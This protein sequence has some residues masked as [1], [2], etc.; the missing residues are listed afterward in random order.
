[1]RRV[2]VGVVMGLAALFF[3]C[4]T[5]HGAAGEMPKEGAKPASAAAAKVP[6]K[7]Y[8]YGEGVVYRREVY[9][10]SFVQEGSQDGP[11]LEIEGNFASARLPN[12]DCYL[13]H[14]SERTIRK[15]DAA[16]NRVYTIAWGGPY[17]RRGGLPE[18]ARFSGGAYHGIMGLSADNQGR[19]LIND[20]Y[21]RLRW[22][23]NPET[24]SIEVAPGGDLNA[25]VSGRAPDG[26]LYYAMGDGKL[27]KLLP[28]G[29]TVQ[30]LGVTLEPPL[31]ITSYFGGLAVSEPTG[32]LYAGSRD[33]YSPW[34]VFWYWDMKTGKALGLAGPKIVDGKRVAQDGGEVDK[35]FHCASGPADKVGFW[36]T[37][38]PSLGPDLGE[39]YLYI[40]GGD[41]STPSRLDLKKRYV[42][43]L[44]RAEPKGD[45]SLWTFGEGRQ[46]R[47]YRFGDP[48]TWPGAPQ[49]GDDGEF[50][51]GA[52]GRLEVFRPVPDKTAKEAEP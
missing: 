12:G 50:Y 43:K 35:N 39:R 37:G 22:V 13:L 18:C 44:V 25:A 24:D 42:T 11:P 27:K 2:A 19:L 51:M 26:S 10:G 47:D 28:D 17:G 33:P 21:N 29:K 6:G 45:R 52:S 8:P 31:V 20:N 9:L 49:W 36:C 16:R 34:G 40:P 14:P 7:D 23:L 4:G 1:M 32:R 15:Y 38:G 48:Y 5:L 3:A 30:D 46:G 41:E